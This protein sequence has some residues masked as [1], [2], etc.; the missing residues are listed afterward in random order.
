MCAEEHHKCHFA[1]QAHRRALINEILFSQRTVFSANQFCTVRKEDPMSSKLQSLLPLI[2]S[3]LGFIMIRFVINMPL[4]DWQVSE[5]VT[6]FP[7]AYEVNIASSPWIASLGDAL[8]DGSYILQEIRVI[9]DGSFCRKEN[10]KFVVKRS[11]NDETVERILNASQKNTSWLFAWGMIG[12][13]LSGIYIWWFITGYK[14]GSAFQAF[15]FMGIAGFIYVFLLLISR[16]LG[17]QPGYIGISDCYGT[18][19][20]SARLS[21]IHY[22][23]LIVL[24][25]SILAELG[26]LGMI[27]RHIIKIV[28]ERKSRSSPTVG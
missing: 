13:T 25:A 28:I 21:Q 4:L 6:D 7:P 1:S 23:T 9:G 15:I 22:E 11:Q 24:F 20:F 17:P 26:A 16:V 10:L 14:Q 2:L 19:T 18:I 27:L 8:D 12:L 5:I 3:S